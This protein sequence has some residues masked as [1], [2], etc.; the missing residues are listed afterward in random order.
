MVEQY[1]LKGREVLCN[2]VMDEMSKK[3]QVEFTGKTMTGYVHLGFQIHSDETEE[4]REVL[5]FTLVGINGHW[6]IPV[7]YLILNGLNSKEKAGVVQ[8][9]IK[10]VHESGVVITSFTFDAPTIT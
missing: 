2:L 9:V 6:K 4:A 8:E 5:V 1:R 7:V 10:F 3:N